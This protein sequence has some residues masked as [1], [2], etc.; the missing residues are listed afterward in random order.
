MV[1]KVQLPYSRGMNNK[2]LNEYWPEVHGQVEFRQGKWDATLPITAA[3]IFIIHDEQVLLT[4]IPRGWDIPGGHIE[5]GETPEVAIVREVYEETGGIVRD[6]RP[7]GYLHVTKQKETAENAKY[8]PKSGI[9]VFAS[10]TVTL[11]VGHDLS[12]FEATECRFVPINIMGEYHHNWS[13][14]KQAGLEYA[15]YCLQQAK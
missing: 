14:M 7:V 5:P 15:I 4:K 12:N 11:N 2:V 10:D 8:P 13:P 1:N 6:C 9:A 3:V